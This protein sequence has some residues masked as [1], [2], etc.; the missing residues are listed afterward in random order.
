MLSFTLLYERKNELFI[1]NR[2]LKQRLNEEIVLFVY[3]VF[4]MNRVKRKRKEFVMAKKKDKKAG[5][6]MTK[7]ELANLVMDYFQRNAGETIGLRKLFSELKLTTHPLKMLCVDILDELAFGDYLTEVE[8]NVYKLNNHGT[9]MV[10]IFQ[11][12]SNGKNLFIPDGGGEPIF[13]AERNSAH[14]MN[15]DKVRITCFA[16]RKN[17]TT[18]GEVEE[19][20]EGDNDTFVGTLQVEK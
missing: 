11:R 14:A 13:I 5:K 15:N 1:C 18:E 10:G 16:K 19:M 7:K 17:Q 12:K 6:R 3:F 2:I 20:L 8:R 9:D 4:H